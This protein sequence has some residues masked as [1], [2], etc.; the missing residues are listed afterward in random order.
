MNT[1]MNSLIIISWVA[2]GFFAAWIGKHVIRSSSPSGVGNLA[3]GILGSLLGGVFTH[4]L[5]G[6]MDPYHSFLISSGGALFFAMF[7]IV[8]TR[9]APK[10]HAQ[11]HV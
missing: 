1:P 11:T 7:L 10:R 5:F 9:F 2:M 8:V 4:S 6:S 3:V